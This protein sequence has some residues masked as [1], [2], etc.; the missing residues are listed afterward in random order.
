MGRGRWSRALLAVM[1]C[2]HCS[3]HP[4]PNPLQATRAAPH[5]S[6]AGAATCWG[7]VLHALGYIPSMDWVPLALDVTSRKGHW[8]STPTVVYSTARANVQ[9]DR[10]R[11]NA[12]PR[13]HSLPS[14]VAWLGLHPTLCHIVI[15]PGCFDRVFRT[16][17]KQSN[18]R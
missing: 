2:T 15:L 5:W 10:A 17:Q 4:Q 6:C 14:V 8:Y 11:Y 7:D 16:L 18:L 13:K 3:S 1:L 9:A 12:T